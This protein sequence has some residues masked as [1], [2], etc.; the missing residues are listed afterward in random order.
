VGCR[1]ASERPPLS[2]SLFLAPFL[3]NAD[4][5]K[6]ALPLRKHVFLLRQTLQATGV[7]NTYFFPIT[8][9]NLF[10]APSH[11]CGRNVISTWNLPT[12][13]TWD[14]VKVPLSFEGRGPQRVWLPVCV[15]VAAC[16][17][18]LC[19]LLNCRLTIQ[20]FPIA[21]RTNCH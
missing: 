5:D 1:P 16:C 11:R 3:E 6:E 4:L 10:S 2:A 9:F 13:Q 17:H 20:T 12:S 7:Q 8:E 14:F 18:L 15:D 19:D 21:V